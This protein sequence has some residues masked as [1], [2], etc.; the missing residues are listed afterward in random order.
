VLVLIHAVYPRSPTRFI[1]TGSVSHCCEFRY[2]AAAL[3]RSKFGL[4]PIGAAE[5]SSAPPGGVSPNSRTVLELGRAAVPA[6]CSV[7]ATKGGD[8]RRRSNA[9]TQGVG[10]TE[11]S[12]PCVGA[13]A[14]SRT[15]ASNFSP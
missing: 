10:E 4:C 1:E 12:R 3:A 15:R 8:L 6:S 9:K 13:S 2:T 7:I 5:K 11:V 14:L